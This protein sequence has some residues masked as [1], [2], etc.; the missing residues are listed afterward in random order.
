MSVLRRY[1]AEIL[2]VGAV[3]G[4]LVCCALPDISWMNTDCDGPHYIYAAKYLHPAHKTSAPLFLLLGHLFLY[5]PWG[6]DAWRFALLSVLASTVTAVFIIA[7]IKHYTGNRWYAVLGALIWGSSALMI[8]Q[9]TII[10]SY[11]LV[12]TFGVGAFYF[13]LKKRWV[14]TAL[15]L[16]LSITVHPLAVF[17]LLVIF[18]ANKEFRKW[19]YYGM[20]AMFLV[21]YAYIPLTS[22]PPYMWFGEGSTSTNF[23]MDNISTIM[24]L[25]GGLSIWDVPKRIF[26]AAG[27]MGASLGLAS[28]VIVYWMWKTSRLNGVKQLLKQPLFWLFMLPVTLYIIN[29]AHQTYVHC[30][31]SIAFGAV[32]AGVMLPRMKPYW[33]YAVAVVAIGLLVFNANYFDV[34]RT[35]DPD[36]SAR[37]FYNEELPKIPDGQILLSQQGWEWAMVFLYNAEED[38]DIT[39][40]CAGALPSPDYQNNLKSQ[41]INL[42]DNPDDP[43][44]VKSTN[45]ALSI[46]ELNENVWTTRP[47]TPRT[48]G[49]E[50]VPARGNEHYL[51][52]F[53]KSVTDGSM[54]MVW[55]WRP[56]NPYDIITGAIE[57]EEWVWVVFSNYTV[58]TFVMMGM[59]GA[60]P[61]WVAYMVLFKKKKWSAKKAWHMGSEVEVEADD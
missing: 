22:R 32:I 36:L 56:S 55:Q 26:D 39:S 59:I 37:K 44:S 41:G 49:A 57:V 50:I 18:I 21:F 5:I 27:I 29:L 60:V 11:A 4:V 38:R 6:T 16:G 45:I 33:G 43:L 13:S 30:L 19:R 58:L 3:F 48:F 14:L 34:G 28:L 9:S 31:P 1:W 8:S 2:V 24:M 12:T 40:I 53:P 47:T 61:M 35:L 46:V 52:V 17:P 23:F 25:V 20:V 7:V 51:G 54:D 42:V 15:F 10:E